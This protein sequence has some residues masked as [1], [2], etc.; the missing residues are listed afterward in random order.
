METIIIQAETVKAK[1]LK[2]FLK[3]F[4]VPFTVEMPQEIPYNAESV[5]KI[6]AR[7]KSAKQ[8]N[9]VLYDDA[10]RKELFGK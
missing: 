3:A 2:Q 6:K 7:S 5:K 8:C 10:L 9:V 4:G 1:A